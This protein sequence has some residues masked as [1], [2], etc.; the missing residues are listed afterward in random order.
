[1]P[2]RRM[3]AARRAQIRAFQLAGARARAQAAWEAKGSYS[4]PK[5]PKLAGLY[6]GGRRLKYGGK[7]YLHK[8]NGSN[9]TIAPFAQQVISGKPVT[10]H[11]KA[12]HTSTIRG[13]MT[14]SG[15]TLRRRRKAGR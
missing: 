10:A 6:G 14:Q 1:M 5:N 12:L 9:V 15:G 7:H 4:A 8:G 3:T 13:D 2:K 11:P